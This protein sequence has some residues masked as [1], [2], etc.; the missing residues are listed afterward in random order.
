MITVVADVV[1]DLG[2]VF[3]CVTCGEML[4]FEHAKPGI[5]IHPTHSS[6]GFFGGKGKELYCQFVGKRFKHPFVMELKEST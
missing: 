1:S 3:R 4:D 2:L 5:L 6:G